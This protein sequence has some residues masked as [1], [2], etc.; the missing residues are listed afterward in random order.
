MYLIYLGYFAW[1]AALGGFNSK[2]GDLVSSV[3]P[4]G[5]ELHLQSTVF[6]RFIDLLENLIPTN[7]PTK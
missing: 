7:I 1:P 4:I 2:N 5:I 6:I 3:A